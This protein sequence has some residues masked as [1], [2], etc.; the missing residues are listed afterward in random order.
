MSE[1]EE[2]SVTQSQLDGCPITKK[3]H[4]KRKASNGRLKKLWRRATTQTKGITSRKEWN[5]MLELHSMWKSCHQDSTD[6]ADDAMM[7]LLPGPTVFLSKQQ[8]QYC[9]NID[10]W[11]VTEGS[12]HRDIIVNF[13]FRKTSVEMAGG[14]GL[15]KKKKRKLEDVEAESILQPSLVNVP[16]LP[17]WSTMCNLGGMGGLAVIEICI[18]DCAPGSPCP[19]MPS[20]RVK[21][22]NARSN[23]SASWTS[24]F[25]NSNEDTTNCNN[26]KV[27]RGIT[28]CKVQLF[29]GNKHPRSLS[30]VLMFLSPQVVQNKH[31]TEIQSSD[32]IDSIY[33]LRLTP[34]QM[35]NE[36]Y[37]FVEERESE[38]SDDSKESV[39]IKIGNFGMDELNDMSQDNVLDLI[40]TVA[41]KVSVGEDN[42]QYIDEVTGCEHYVKTFSRNEDASTR[43]PKVFSID[44]EMVQTKAGVELARV[45]IIEFVGDRD[46]EKITLVLGKWM[47]YLT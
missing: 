27:Q 5:E 21:E 45:S 14:S 35:A 6:L 8:S 31:D 44:C 36:G 34:K 39:Q 38:S 23:T 4:K 33:K 2:G 1:K 22:V 17:S 47:L 20:E 37:P 40:K 12:D 41:S 16:K 3:K 18:E 26:S 10:N 11:Q 19:F 25:C 28:A 29:Q 7:G 42:I 46:D 13:L 9:T 24:L 15:K 43:R 30:D 32:I